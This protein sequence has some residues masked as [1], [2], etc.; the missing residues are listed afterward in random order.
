MEATEKLHP[1]FRSAGGRPILPQGVMRMKDAA[2]ED[3]AW[4]F[5][6]KPQ[7]VQAQFSIQSTPTLH[8]RFPNLMGK[9]DGKTGVNHWDAVLK[10]Y[11]GDWAKAEEL[12]H[13]QPRGTCGGRAG[14]FG[15]DLLQH[16]LIASGK[17]F[18]FH[19]VSH[20][21][22]YYMARKLYGWIGGGN[23]QNDND[24]GVA[25][26]SVPRAMAE[27]GVS[28]REEST[29]EKWYG[30]GSDDLACQLVAGLRTDLAKKILELASDNLVT[31]WATAKSAQELA[32]GIAAGGVGIGSDMQGYTMTR[33][34]DGYCSPRGQW[35]HYH[36]RSGVG[37]NARGRKGFDYTQSWGKTT[38]DGPKLPGRPGNVFGVDWDVQ[39]R[40]CRNGEWA[41]VFGFDIW[42]LEADKID[43]PWI[44]K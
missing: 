37:V 32:D 31:A 22:V 14:S 21:A 13:Y 15:M 24:D 10:N 42:D 17:R 30:E 44:F 36:V 2:P 19:R 33:D 38:P 5:G 11:S 27:M 35:A 26:G 1:I 23:W 34:A 4:N 29:D 12:I 9:W 43:I 6:M 20:A 40:L 7:P 3:I 18:K 25:G 16:I 28:H 39:D 8:Q 41:V